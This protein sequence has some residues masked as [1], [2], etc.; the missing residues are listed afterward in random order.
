MFTFY[1][2]V[3]RKKKSPHVFL[4][5]PGFTGIT[6]IVGFLF[7]YCFSFL[8]IFISVVTL[9]FSNTDMSQAE[10][11]PEDMPAYLNDEPVGTGKPVHLLFSSSP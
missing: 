5:P 11:V 2:V 7:A 4:R 6:G 10:Q 3:K 1:L 8:I 9:C